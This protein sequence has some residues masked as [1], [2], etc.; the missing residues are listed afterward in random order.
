MLTHI[1]LCQ[2]HMIGYDEGSR[3]IDA[4]ICR[5]GTDEAYKLLI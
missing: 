3:V 4:Y 5:D 2:I 1:T